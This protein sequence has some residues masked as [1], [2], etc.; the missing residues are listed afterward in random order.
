MVFCVLSVGN[1]NVDYENPLTDAYRKNHIFD[2]VDNLR[3]NRVDLTIGKEKVYQAFSITNSDPYHA[4]DYR[5]DD[6]YVFNLWKGEDTIIEGGR[7]DKIVF[8]EYLMQSSF[9]MQVT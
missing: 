5:G 8:R 1:K 3:K 9:M 2:F 4:I 6:I 7:T